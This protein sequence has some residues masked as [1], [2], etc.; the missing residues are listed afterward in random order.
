MSSIV[1]PIVSF[2]GWLRSLASQALQ[3]YA[4]GSTGYIQW[5]GYDSPQS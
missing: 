2:A 1:R 3:A 5:S 4:Q